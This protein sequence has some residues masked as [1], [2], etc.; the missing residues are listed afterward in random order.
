MAQTFENPFT[1]T[2]RSVTGTRFIGRKDGLDEIEDKVFA[3]DPANLAI[4]GGP[5]MGKS[6]LVDQ[7]IV[8]H[9]QKI[10]EKNILPIR[11]N[12]GTYQRS[13]DFFYALPKLALREL[14]KRGYQLDPYL[15][16]AAESCRQEERSGRVA[17]EAIQY[18]F[19]LVRLLDIRV[20][21]ILDEFDDTRRL[22]KDDEA[23][24]QRLRELSYSSE[25]SV[26]YITLSRRTIMQIELQ[27]GVNST[28]DGIFFFKYYVRPFEADDLQDYYARLTDIGISVTTALKK[29]LESYTGGSPTLLEHL[30]YEIVEIFRKQQKVDVQAAYEKTK[31]SFNAY[32]KRIEK[33]LR[34]DQSFD[35][36]LQITCG[37][38]VDI[39]KSD[40]DDFQAY[41]LIKPGPKNRF[42]AFSSDFQ[43]YLRITAQQTELWPLLKDTEIALRRAIEDALYRVYLEQ[44]VE[45]VEQKRPKIKE[46]FSR[47][48][49]H[50][51]KDLTNFGQAPSSILD[52]TYIRDLFTI[53]ELE[54]D[55]AS[56]ASIL[57]FSKAEWQQRTAFLQN[58]RNAV[59]HHN[60][61]AVLK[62]HHKQ[63]AEIYL[64]E[65][66]NALEHR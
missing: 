14:E 31:T 60:G 48:R 40:V 57:K 35:K 34:E 3:S 44:W 49:D 58:V 63:Q 6:S 28:L 64:N 11:I 29:E 39:T 43:K 55:T 9:Q 45:K 19:E 50:Q 22:F 26:T 66:K 46:I 52:S 53:I 59:A 54:W 61:E 33:R 65:I 8:L 21:F 24:F 42:T 23:G 56:F 30:S 10:R 17:F 16:I 37:P 2:G 5:G 51:K 27:T 4:I 13:F 38:V 32:Y 18:F 20:L 36:L 41:G 25:C 7:A 15:N 47:C 62:E 12:L 1:N